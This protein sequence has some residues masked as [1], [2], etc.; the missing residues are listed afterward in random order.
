MSSRKA[1]C[2]GARHQGKEAAA[3][4]LQQAPS[5]ARTTHHYALVAAALRLIWVTSLVLML[6]CIYLCQGGFAFTT[7]SEKVLSMHYICMSIAWPAQP[8]RRRLQNSAM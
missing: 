4:A 5:A 3:V 1:H 6:S 8:D 2:P 7:A